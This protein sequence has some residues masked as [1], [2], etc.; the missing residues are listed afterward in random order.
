MRR[1]VPFPKPEYASSGLSSPLSTAAA[2]ARTDAV[3]IGRAL[4]TTEKIAPAK[5]ANRRHAGTLSP[6]GGAR[7]PDRRDQD[8]SGGLRHDGPARLGH[9]RPACP[10]IA[11]GSSTSAICFSVRIFFSRT[12]SMMP[13][14]VFIAS[15]ASSVDFS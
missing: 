8:G 13:R 15:A 14:P 6:S 10:V 1:M 9:Q 5:S 3:R 12:S 11:R 4:T 2:T 7:P